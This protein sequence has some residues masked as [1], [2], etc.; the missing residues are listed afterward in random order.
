M[1]LLEIYNKDKKVVIKLKGT[2][3]KYVFV[4]QVQSGYLV[5]E[6]MNNGDI[7]KKSPESED[8]EISRPPK[9]KTKKYL[10]AYILCN[11]HRTYLTTTFYKD[12]CEFLSDFSDSNVIYY[13]KILNSEIEI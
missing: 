10:Y 11:D 2:D 13:Q 3:E 4:G 12:D 8:Y 5:L 6:K 7:C 9:Q 1:T